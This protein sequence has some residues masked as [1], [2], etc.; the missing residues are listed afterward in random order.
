MAAAVVEFFKKAK[1][2]WLITKG[3]IYLVQEADPIEYDDEG[4]T[5]SVWTAV[6]E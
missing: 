3:Q 2:Q 1:G 4:V 6:D 5:W